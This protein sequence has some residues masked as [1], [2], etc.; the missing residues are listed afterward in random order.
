MVEYLT[1]E[2]L[3]NKFRNNFALANFAIDMAK[4][5]IV[6]GSAYTLEEV[7]VN[8]EKLPDADEAQSNG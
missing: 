5:S 8:L 2:R 1:N 7:M 4:D 3:R 6:K